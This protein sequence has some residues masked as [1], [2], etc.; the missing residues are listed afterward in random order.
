MDSREQR[1]NDGRTTR[2]ELAYLAIAF[3]IIAIMYATGF[4]G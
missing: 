2:G 3:V 4:G 1:P